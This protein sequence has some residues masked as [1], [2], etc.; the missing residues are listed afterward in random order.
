MPILRHALLAAL[1]SS[2]A[3]AQQSTQPLPLKL[4]P[5]KT[6]PAI[7]IADLMTRIYRFADDSMRGRMAGSPEAMK[8]TEYIAGELKRLG[9]Q[10]AGDSGTY[11]QNVPFGVQT[12]D[13]S[14]TIQIGETTF[15]AG[16]DFLA[17]A[18]LGTPSEPRTLE[19]IFGGQ[20]I[21]TMNVLAPE[22]V[23]GKLLLLLPAAAPPTDVQAFINSEGF[24]RYQASVTAAAVIAL[25]GPAQ[26]PPTVV[27][28]AFTP[29]PFVQLIPEQPPTT[30]ATLQLTQP[31]ATALLGAPNA[32]P[33]KGSAG[34]T[35]RGWGLHGSSLDGVEGRRLL[36]RGSGPGWGALARAPGG[37]RLAGAAPAARRE[38]FR[39]I[40]PVA[41]LRRAPDGLVGRQ[42][43]W[44]GGG[45]RLR[46]AG[47]PTCGR[48][49][50]VLR[51]RGG[52]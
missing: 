25:V 11:Y 24:K 33:A 1:V 5:T 10:P 13:S 8:G 46:R 41:R 31:A 29:S 43:R 16:N 20:A 17:S 22:K 34:K 42:R 27:R 50:P 36:S 30:P 6:A 49:A 2:A 35:A 39:A 47:C 32:M 18:P 9:L 14:S 7:T 51:P 45:A 37:L 28:N 21:D 4:D 12:L 19:V 48:A 26:F 15:K 40:C 44:P 23:R 52:P 38:R 3:A